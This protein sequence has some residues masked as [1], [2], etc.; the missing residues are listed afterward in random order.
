MSRR[1][2]I[3]GASFSSG[4]A[5]EQETIDFMASLGIADDATAY[6]PATIYERTGNQFFQYMNTLVLVA[7]SIGL[8]KFKTIWPRLGG[9]AARHGINLVNP[10]NTDAAHRSE[11][12]GGWVH[13]PTGALPNGTNSH[14]NCHI[15]PTQWTPNSFTNGFY[16]RQAPTPSQIIAG[17]YDAYAGPNTYFFTPVWDA[18]NGLSRY[19]TNN[20]L[21]SAKTSGAGLHT[22]TQNAT[23]IKTHYNGN[24][25]RTIPNIPLPSFQ[26]MTFNLYS[27]GWS[28]GGLAENRSNKENAFEFISDALTDAENATWAA[29]IQ[30][31]NTSLGRNV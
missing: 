17:V 28:Y 21:F 15:N 7:K 5:W 20:N 1:V 4:P 22:F 18:T 31:F 13:G 24:L 9:T 11:F 6:Y 30:A 2:S 10:A 3:F 16:L 29:A 8:A 27:A 25:E 26:T 19:G 14:V 12:F 23:Q